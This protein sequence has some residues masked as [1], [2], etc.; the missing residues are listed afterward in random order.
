MYARIERSFSLSGKAKS[1][2]INYARCLAHIAV[3]YKMSPEKLD[4]ESIEDYLF[5]CKEQHKTPS[6]SFFKHTIYGL[7]A[8]YKVMNLPD[9][10][11]GLPQIKAQKNLPIV[12]SRKE[13]KELLSTPKYLQHRLILA[14][15]YGCGLRTYELCNL[16]IA[17]IDFDR[18]TVFIKKQKG[19]IDRYL[20]L[21]DHLARGLKKHLAAEN[22]VTHIFESRVKK[23]D[24]SARQITNSN[25][26]WLIKECR[27]KMATHKKF[28]CHSLRHTYATH[29]L[30]DGVNIL[31][32]QK[33]LGHTRIETTLIYLHVAHIEPSN[34]IN[35][36]DNLYGDAEQI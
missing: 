17:D 4:E 31:T 23:A 19:R 1:T 18:K 27:S 35:A 30:E 5:L 6:A 25:T 34:K 32:V 2:L 8:A 13:V 15:F 16:E 33:L 12:L 11:I 20:P 36:L 14:L 29:L 21:S 7:R 3:H 22:P 26:Q 28:T 9:R 24:G 10:K